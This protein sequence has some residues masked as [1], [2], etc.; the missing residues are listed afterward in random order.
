MKRTVCL[1]TN[2]QVRWRHWRA[3]RM[4]FAYLAT[5]QPA[6]NLDIVYYE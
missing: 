3:I 4:L 1:G 5:P 6:G 2:W